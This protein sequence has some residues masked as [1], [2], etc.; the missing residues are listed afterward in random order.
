M[1]RHWRGGLVTGMVAA[2]LVASSG[3]AAVAPAPSHRGPK[4]ATVTIGIRHRVFHDFNDVQRVKLNQEF[5]V[6]DTDYTG[7]IV[8]YVPDFTM[9]LKTRKVTSRSDQPKNPAFK[10]IV[11][12]NKVPQDTAWAF[13]NI[14]PHFGSKSLLAFKVLRIDFAGAPPLLADTTKTAPGAGHP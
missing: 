12:Q 1:R 11:R 6:G 4:V 5:E 8:Q 14:P 13:L 2:A 9:D 7:R 3:I 10:I